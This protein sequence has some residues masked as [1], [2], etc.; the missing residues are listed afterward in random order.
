MSCRD[1]MAPEDLPGGLEIG[2]SAVCPAKKCRVAS[3]GTE[4]HEVVVTNRSLLTYEVTIDG[5]CEMS[6]IEYQ[7]LGASWTPPVLIVPGRLGTGKSQ[8]S[9]DQ[10]LVSVTAGEKP[11]IRTDLSFGA[12]GRPKVPGRLSFQVETT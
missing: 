6:A 12:A 1:A 11:T 2:T 8:R 7:G 4:R 5:E 9:R 10:P 3:S